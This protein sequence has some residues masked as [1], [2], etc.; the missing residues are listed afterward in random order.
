MQGKSACVVNN[1]KIHANSGP[2]VRVSLQARL[3]LTSSLLYE[4]QDFGIVFAKQA[5]GSVE[6]CD[7]S[8][9]TRAEMIITESSSA[10]ARRCKLHKSKNTG[11]IVGEN[12]QGTL[13]DCDL[14]QN[15]LSGVE[16]RPGASLEMRSCTVNRNHHSGIIAQQDSQGLIES[17][18]LRG[19]QRD[20]CAIDARSRLQQSNNK[21]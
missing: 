16:V 12:A 13:E 1:S 19:N 17:C 10:L 3:E 9:H 6:D 8:A 4:G 18:D 21:L 14:S 11:L 5:Q 7:I 2:G 20:A 15:M